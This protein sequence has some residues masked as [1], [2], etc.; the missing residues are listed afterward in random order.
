MTTE[1]MRQT[2]ERS[3]GTMS[4]PQTLESRWQ[5]CVWQMWGLLVCREISLVIPAGW[6]SKM[7]AH[8]LSPMQ[9]D[10]RSG[11][12]LLMIAISP[13]SIL[14]QTFQAESYSKQSQMSCI[15]NWWHSLQTDFWCMFLIAL[16]P[17]LEAWRS[18][19]RSASANDGLSQLLC[20]LSRQQESLEPFFSAM[21]T[22]TV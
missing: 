18:A 7:A 2:L 12:Y 9:C 10:R 21:L 19:L 13:F 17:F 11:G 4:G 14:Y 22:H 20:R 6:T 15:L 5:L 16:G 1:M 3:L 8:T